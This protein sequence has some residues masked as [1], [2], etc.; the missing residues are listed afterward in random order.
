MSDHAVS[1]NDPARTFSAPE[2]ILG[3]L[4][5]LRVALNELLVAAGVDPAKT[6][7][8]ARELD[9]DRNLVWRMTRLA[10]AED[11]LSVTRDIPAA[12][13]FAKLCEVCR[14]RGAASE[15]VGRVEAAVANFEAMVASCLGDR[16]TLDAL[17]AGLEYEDVTQRQESARK[18]AFM[19]NSSVWGVQAR[20]NFKATLHAP[21]RERADRIRTARLSGLVQFRRLRQ[22]EWPIHR[23]HGYNDDGSV[24]QLTPHPLEVR[25]EVAH[26]LPLLPQFCSHPLPEIRTVK[27]SYGR[28]YELPAGPIGNAGALTCVFADVF[29]PEFN[30]FRTE[31]ERYLASMIDLVTPSEAV[32][33]DMFLHRD[34]EFATSPEALLLDRL[35]IERGYQPGRDE[36]HQLPLSARPLRLGT[37]VA[38]AASPQFPEY[39]K[40]LQHVIGKL[41][42]DPGEFRGYR[43]YL[44]YPPVPSA[45]VMRLA[46]PE[47]P[48]G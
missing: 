30:R 34:L 21:S 45:L 47:A 3:V 42:H 9:L 39:G 31:T 25:T 11:I 27:T 15:A 4:L 5:E 23:V 10:S 32:I 43:V 24:I 7:A 17:A 14:E 33:L 29:T 36:Q 26:D 46:Y 40:L 38:G 48:G 12:K 28:R 13:H 20:V 16:E 22:V 44:R 6:R 8:T 35:S 37:G 19:G 2:D 41:D 1:E 18:L